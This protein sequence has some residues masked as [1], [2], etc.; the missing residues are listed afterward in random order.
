M[1][2]PFRIAVPDPVL[3]D[4]RERLGRTRMP[5]AVAGVGWDQ[6]TEPQ[7]LRALLEHW[8]SGYD[9]RAHE[10]LLN[11]FPQFMAQAGGQDLHFIHA[12]SPHAEARPLLIVH[13]WPGSV[14]EFYKLIPL[15]TGPE[16]HGGRAADAFHVVAPSL[17]GYGFSPAPQRPGADPRH[18]AGLLHALMSDALGYGRYW[19]QGGD[20][21]SVIASWLAFDQPRA[22]AGLHLN[23]AGL[24]PTLGPEAAP[25]SEAE[26]VF[27]AAARLKRS[28]EFGYQA[29]Q[30]SRPQT[31]GYGL[32]DSP[33]GLAAW[34]L[35]K[36]RAWSDCGGEV[37]RAFSKDELL[38]N[39][40]LYWVTGTI[41]S[42]MRLYYE[43]RRGEAGPPA[44]Q[45]VEVPTAFAEF[46]AEILPAP[47][48]WV[49]RVYNVVRWTEM[50]RGGHFA[51]LEQPALLAAD[52]RAAFAG[53]RP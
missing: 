48:A 43:Y 38:T 19:A 40:M 42:S 6:G 22:V 1:P 30:G 52:V 4:L 49:E 44:G 21:G 41:T 28:D 9:W 20:W 7:A 13:G 11:G 25:L 31:L 32:N 45:R 33:A 26:R 24:R 34:L 39:I 50:P 10:A 35:E 37:E 15:L 53:Q 16:A 14:Y 18:V 27:L 47:R 51:A 36:F 3:T 12:R 8:R 23:M 29:I 2:R 46:P 5:D 17:P